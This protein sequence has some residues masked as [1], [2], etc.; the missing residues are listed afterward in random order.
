MRGRARRQQGEPVAPPVIHELT[1]PDALIAWGKL[2]GRRWPKPWG[3]EV[4]RF[5]KLGADRHLTGAETGA[6][7]SRLEA[8]CVE[9]IRAGEQ[10]LLLGLDLFTC[11]WLRLRFSF[12]SDGRKIVF[13]E[14]FSYGELHELLASGAPHEAVKLALQSKE[15]LNDVFPRAK[16]DAIIDA[17]AASDACFGCGEG[18]HAVMFTLETGSVYCTKC[19]SYLTEKWPTPEELGLKRGKKRT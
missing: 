11:S 6:L 13:G 8:L 14:T 19:W 3:H 1:I 5:V 18:G 12:E 16:I 7:L 17:D 9:A 10:Q 15:L 4:E 2:N